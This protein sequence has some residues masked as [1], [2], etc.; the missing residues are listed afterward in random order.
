MD[1]IARCKFDTP[2]WPREAGCRPGTVWRVRWIALHAASFIHPP[3]TWARLPTWR[4]LA[5]AMDCIARCKF[6]TPPWPREAG[7]QPAGVWHA[8]WIALHVVSFIHPPWAPGA[9]CQPAGAWQA[10]WIALHVVSFIHPPAHVGQ[11]AKPAKVRQAPS[12]HGLHCAC[13]FHTPP[14]RAHRHARDCLA[15]ARATA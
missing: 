11:V 14:P 15:L 3:G 2:P 9:G 4:G 12:A 13:Q 1:C 5:G 6:H 7:C 10:G 8:R